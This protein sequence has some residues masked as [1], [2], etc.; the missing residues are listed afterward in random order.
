MRPR[1]GR[2]FVQTAV[3]GA[4]VALFAGSASATIATWGD[5]TYGQRTISGAFVGARAVGAGYWHTLLVHSNGSVVAVG[6]N[7]SGEATVPAGL[8][9]VIA[10]SGGRDHSLALR[11]DGTV[12]AWGD[13]TYGQTNVP[14]GL[15]GVAAISAGGFHNLALLADGTVRAWGYAFYGQIAVPGDLTNVAAV[16]AGNA[17]S[18][19]LCSNGTVRGWGDNYYHQIDIPA[20][21]TNAIAIAAGFAHALAVRNDGS[22]VM[23]G[24]TS[25]GQGTVPSTLTNAVAVSAGR[26]HSMAMT[27]IG[28]VICWGTNNAGQ[29]TVPASSSNV[30][31][32][33]A[34][35]D[36][37]VVLKNDA[38]IIWRHPT[39]L[40][41]KTGTNVTFKVTATGQSPA[42]LWHFNGQPLVGAASSN[43]LRIQG[44]AVTNAGG[45]H[46]IL[47]NMV[48][49][50][51]SQVATLTVNDV[52][53][54]GIPII[55]GN[56][57]SRSVD[58]GADATFNVTA[59]GAVPLV[60]RWLHGGAEIPGAGDQSYT[61]T[62]AQPADA[63][64]YWAIVSNGVGAATSSAASLTLRCAPAFTQQP[65]S[66]MTNAGATVALSCLATGSIPIVYTWHF[67][68]SPLAGV[69]NTLY[70]HN[71]T[72][73]EAGE[74]FAVASN[75]VGAVTSQVAIL[76][77][78][79]SPEQL[80]PVI[81]GQPANRQ[82]LQGQSVTFNV[83]VG[84][85]EPFYFQW[86]SGGS[87][88]ADETGPSYT[89]PLVTPSHAGG[90]SVIVSN[91]FG[92][93]TS[94]TAVLTVGE[95]PEITGHPQSVNAPYGSRVEFVVHA[96]G[97]PAISCRWFRN[98]VSLGKTTAPG[99][100]LVLTSVTL[101]QQ[102]SYHA[103]V[104][105]WVGSAVSDPAVLTVYTN[106]LAMVP[107]SIISGESTGRFVR[108]TLAL[109]AG[110]NYRVQSSSN[111]V[112]WDDVTNFLSSSATADF[113]GQTDTNAA[114]RFY[115]VVSP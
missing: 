83:T 73:N 23:W 85:V 6:R 96:T 33:A 82:V 7:A 53:G 46:C 56:P 105:N 54:S 49:S 26:G 44:V 81:T 80:A 88:L 13:N 99:S 95:A 51:T 104:S 42:Y 109:E 21:L 8:A 10:V 36:H 48:G 29:V 62:G 110:C 71:V 102:G 79:G 11:A 40:V 20:D 64:L 12:A 19:A 5:N 34:G 75:S 78:V 98:G 66:Q 43:D 17:F 2:G 4:V 92:A 57:S 61:V 58:P 24:D 30:L 76:Q 107:C 31:A 72:T 14:P 111:L 38:P 27:A 1:S 63:G 114:L 87:P 100:P 28:R 37:S 60:Y 101:D 113:L 16:A 18:L 39:N 15:A 22:V 59:T 77:V 108:L 68:G 112:D 90:Y 9:D 32:V 97:S 84:G 74:Y 103:V 70:R 115:R 106:G 89:I 25:L 35:F 52:A 41:A 69:S 67:E 45:Y 55:T 47:T 3:C 94:R 91:D 93:V 86:R 65:R 50:A